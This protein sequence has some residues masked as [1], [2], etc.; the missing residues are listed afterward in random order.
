M[1]TET[2][3]NIIG[4][5]LIVTTGTTVLVRYVLPYISPRTIEFGCYC[6]G[7][8]LT[9]NKYWLHNLVNISDDSSQMLSLPGQLIVPATLLYTLDSNDID[10]NE[11]SRTLMT[12]GCLFWG[13]NA[14]MN[15]S[16]FSGLLST[17]MLLSLGIDFITPYIKKLDYNFNLEMLTATSITTY[18]MV[19][20]H[21]LAYTFIYPP[22]LL[23]FQPAIYG[24]C[25]NML[26]ISNL[27][28]SDRDATHTNN[29]Y[30][31]NNLLACA[32][33]G[34]L[35]YFNQLFFGDSII[36]DVTV[37][38]GYIYLVS[39]YYDVPWSDRMLATFVLGLGMMFG[40]V[41]IKEQFG[42]SVGRLLS[43]TIEPMRI[44]AGVH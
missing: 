36:G 12:L 1:N 28:L 37:I 24:G 13:H 31:I 2:I 40:P 39:K 30:M 9:Y 26:Y 44:L 34:Q 20:G 38:N 32:T 23:P 35:Y 25:L 43:L 41:A 11:H 10:I 29:S 8:S 4:S 3:I 27:I 7:T 6:V 21:T 19:W 18:L 14:I 15:E 33:L 5:G 17:T 42:D 22:Y 16:S